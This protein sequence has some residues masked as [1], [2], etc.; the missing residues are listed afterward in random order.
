MLG[1]SPFDLIC[2]LVQVPC[3]LASKF[4]VCF[5]KICTMCELLE[6]QSIRTSTAL[7]TLLCNAEG[8]TF[9]LGLF[10][11]SFFDASQ[12]ELLGNIL[13]NFLKQMIALEQLTSR[14]EHRIISF[15]WFASSEAFPSA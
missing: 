5:N 10:H 2:I 7:S 4:H 8:W 14:A 3:F 11:K 15:L 9:L 1:K 12:S 6:R 13:S